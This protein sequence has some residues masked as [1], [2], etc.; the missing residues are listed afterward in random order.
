MH[1]D[2]PSSTCP[3]PLRWVSSGAMRCVGRLVAGLDEK[4]RLP[5]DANWEGMSAEFREYCL[6]ISI[7]RAPEVTLRS[8]PAHAP[9]LKRPHRA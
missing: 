8:H 5:I 9:L 7:K 6:R 2:K 1:G 3:V 4:I